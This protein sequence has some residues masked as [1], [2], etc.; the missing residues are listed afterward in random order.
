M[1]GARREIGAVRTLLDSALAE[2]QRL[3]R[4][5]QR[6]QE[7][8]QRLEAECRRLGNAF[9]GAREQLDES[10]TTRRAMEATRTWRLH[11]RLCRIGVLARLVRVL[12]R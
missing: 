2:R 3:E 7:E 4:E 11:D 10:E 9:S 12:N 1:A 8:C 6:L 5:R